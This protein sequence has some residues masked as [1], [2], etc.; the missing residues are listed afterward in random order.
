[1][2]NYVFNFS[3][4]ISNIYLGFARNPV[5]EENRDDPNG[6]ILQAAE[7]FMHDDY[8]SLTATNQKVNNIVLIRL[9]KKIV[10]T[11][12]VRPIPIAALDNF[13]IPPGTFI[14]QTG[15]LHVEDN[16]M[17][18]YSTVQE[19]ELD[20][21]DVFYGDSFLRSQER[22]VKQ[23]DGPRNKWSGPF[24]VN[25]VLIGLTRSIQ[26]SASCYVTSPPCDI[27]DVYISLETFLLWIYRISGAVGVKGKKIFDRD[28]PFWKP[29]NEP[30][31]IDKPDNNK[32]K[33]TNLE[34]T[35]NTS[36]NIRGPALINMIREGIN[37]GKKNIKCITQD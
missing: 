7:T 5:I 18:R 26:A 22:C 19:K 14:N 24:V 16:D 29:E 1:M 17:L 9:N 8:G 13:P 10:P 15:F 31:T 2:S 30:S 27:D 12:T 11:K 33:K 36:L 28:N 34:C 37:K 4:E 6:Q 23:K 21:C 3:D 20:V 35:N 25:G 32:P